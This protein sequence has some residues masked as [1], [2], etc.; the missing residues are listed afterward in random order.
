VE[1]GYSAEQAVG[2]AGRCL[3]CGP[4]SECMACVHACKPGAVI[5]E[6]QEILATLDIGAIL[7]CGDGD[8]LDDWPALQRVESLPVIANDPLAASAGAVRAM[9]EL[10]AERQPLERAGFPAAFSLSSAGAGGT[11]GGQALG[12]FV[13]ECGG[14]ISDV[15]DTA[16]IC[17]QARTWPGVVHAQVL[18]FSCSQ[19]AAAAMSSAIHEHKLRGAVLAACSCC[20]IDQVCY[21][22]TY[23]RVRCKSNLGILRELPSST[24][25]ER[26]AST[27][28]TPFEFVN[29]REQCAWAHAED[30]QEATGKALA[31]TAA[32]VA[33]LRTAHPHVIDTPSVERSVLVLGSGAAA[34]PSVE[35]LAR[36]GIA[37]RQIRGVPCG[38][39]RTNRRYQ[40]AQA[41]ASWEAQALVL[42]PAGAEV[43]AM[44]SSFGND[45]KRPRI[46]SAWGEAVTHRP[47]VFYCDPASDPALAG[48]AAAARC[49]AW[50]GRSDGHADPITAVVDP[51]R[52]RA[53]GTCVNVCEFG[54]PYLRGQDPQ[55]SSWIDP[56]ICTGCGTCAAHCPSGA[57]VAGSATD[58]QLE[59]MVVAALGSPGPTA[60]AANPPGLAP[61]AGPSD[62][63]VLV[64]TCN[65][66]AYSALETAGRDRLTYN[67]STRPIKVMCLGQLNPGILLKAFEKGADGVLLLGCSPGECHYEFGNHHAEEVFAQARE[68]ALELGIGEER[69]QLDSVG[70]GEGKRFLEKVQ[71]FCAGLSRKPA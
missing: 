64:L 35:A 5:H 11:Q 50:L 30:H 3:V 28:D 22:C 14:E 36:Q 44:L 60:S 20:A 59:R 9:F 52:C 39:L 33:K 71:A 66:G 13:C 1:L 53:C 18:P 19:E 48:A 4:C 10:F 21:S 38:V 24:C 55:R 63:R 69:L 43:G 42:A 54:A 65:W 67:P 23:Q 8:R 31:L 7:Y 25:G 27:P 70:A 2:E 61:D 46:A 6:E 15:V 26:G 58:V 56:A 41:A 32:T 57:I 40:V 51:A 68:M 49:A 34:R 29:I 45:G 37:V 47:G 16:A 17:T 62:L 12:V